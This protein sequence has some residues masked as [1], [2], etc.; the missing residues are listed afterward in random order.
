MWY[1]NEIV[2]GKAYRILALEHD[3]K[4][5]VFEFLE[6]LEQNNRDNHA[7]LYRNLEHAA[8]CG[9]TNNIE[10]FRRVGNKVYEFKVKAVRL[11]CFFDTGKI[12]VCCSGIMKGKQ[13]E[14]NKAIQRAAKI[15]LDYLEMKKQNKIKILE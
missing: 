9:P 3:G 14:Q 1:L 7:S 15:Y 5:E 2:N 11:F 4:C 10:K 13:K 12:I 8:E 6:T